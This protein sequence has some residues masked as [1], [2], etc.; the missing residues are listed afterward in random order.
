MTRSGKEGVSSDSR[1]WPGGRGRGRGRGVESVCDADQAFEWGAPV[2]GSETPD[3]SP[4]DME[5]GSE[6]PAHYGR[7]RLSSQSTGLQ[8]GQVLTPVPTIPIPRSR[9]SASKSSIVRESSQEEKKSVSSDG[10]NTQPGTSRNPADQDVDDWIKTRALS[11]RHLQNQVMTL[12]KV[13][14]RLQKECDS[15]KSGAECLTSLRSSVQAREMPSSPGMRP[16]AAPST[17]STS[18]L[19]C[20][21]SGLYS[22]RDSLS[23]SD[24]P[25][26][27]DRVASSGAAASGDM[28]QGVSDKFEQ[29]GV[30]RVSAEGRS[31]RLMD[32]G[33]LGPQAEDA[34]NVDTRDLETPQRLSFPLSGKVAMT[35]QFLPSFNTNVNPVSS[36][37]SSSTRPWGILVPQSDSLDTPSEP[38]YFLERSFFVIGK[39]R[40]CDHIIQDSRFADKPLCRIQKEDSVVFITSFTNNSPLFVNGSLLRKQARIPLQ[41]GDE[42]CFVGEHRSYFLYFITTADLA[43]V[44]APKSLEGRTPAFGTSSSPLLHR[45]EEASG[46]G[47]FSP[48]REANECGESNPSSQESASSRKRMFSAADAESN[49]ASD[50]EMVVPT[51]TVS[52]PSSPP[53]KRSQLDKDEDLR[54]SV[55]HAENIRC[56]SQ[57]SRD[58][59]AFVAESNCILS[60]NTCT[61]L[62]EFPYHLSPALKD[63]LIGS[64]SLILQEPSMCSV[65]SQFSALSQRVLLLAPLGGERYCSLLAEGMAH[66]FGADLFVLDQVLQRRTSSERKPLDW[67]LLDSEISA[68]SCNQSA[69]AVWPLPLSGHHDE[70]EDEDDG[71]QS[72][73]LLPPLYEDY[74]SVMKVGFAS[75]DR[76]LSGHVTSS[77]HARH[78]G[79]RSGVGSAKDSD[80]GR[81]SGRKGGR[82]EDWKVGSV[83]EFRGSGT[84]D[85]PAARNHTALAQ[86][87]LEGAMRLCAGNRFSTPPVPKL[88]GLRPGCRGIVQLFFEKNPRIVCVKFE[89]PLRGSHELPQVCPDG[90]GVFVPRTSLRF[91]GPEG[92]F[93][94]SAK[95]G[96]S[97]SALP[98]TGHVSLTTPKAA[99]KKPDGGEEKVPQPMECDSLPLTADPGILKGEQDGPCATRS[100]SKDR[101]MGA[102]D[103]SVG[104][105]LPD[106]DEPQSRDGGEPQQSGDWSI[107]FGASKSGAGAG[108]N[109]PRCGTPSFEDPEWGPGQA[110]MESL[111]MTVDQKKCIIHEAM[112]ILKRRQSS[113]PLI[114]Y[115]GDVEGVLSRPWDFARELS[116]LVRNIENKPVVILGASFDTKDQGEEKQVGSGDRGACGNSLSISNRSLSNLLLNVPPNAPSGRTPTATLMLG[117]NS[118]SSGG[119]GFFL[120]PSV[121]PPG[122]GGSEPFYGR[123]AEMSG[124]HRLSRMMHAIGS[125]GLDLSPNTRNLRTSYP[126]KVERKSS[127]MKS[128]LERMFP[129]RM[130]IVKPSHGVLGAEW[131]RRLRED[132][133]QRN[134]DFNVEIFQQTLKKLNT[135][136]EAFPEEKMKEEKFDRETIERMCAWAVS[137]ELSS[138]RQSLDEKA[139]PSYSPVNT[140]DNGS[141]AL[142]VEEARNGSPPLA[143]DV[144][145]ASKAPLLSQKSIIYALSLHE[146]LIKERSPKVTWLETERMNEF[147]KRLLGDVILAE[148]IGVSFQDIGSLDAFKKTLREVVMLPLQR[149][150]L[151]RRGNLAKAVKGLLLFGPPGTGKTMLAKAVATESGANFLNINMSSIGSKWFG[152]A[153][154]YA[155]AVFTLARK[156]APCII[157]VDE[158]DSMLGQRS[159]SGEHEAMRKIKNE[160]MSGWDGLK[161]KDTEQVLVLGATNRPFDLDEAVLRRMPRR[162]LVDT[163]DLEERRRIL[164]VILREEEIHPSLSILEIAAK[165]DGFTGSDLKNLCVNAAYRPLR[166]LIDREEKGEQISSA[167]L[168]PLVLQ[169]FIEALK[170]ISPSVSEDSSSIQELRQW[171]DMYGEGG[172]RSRPTLPYFM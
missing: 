32:R 105:E 171:N 130:A 131:E 161:S 158:I 91:L 99:A 78:K 66:H 76:H 14:E 83:V 152:E 89:Q 52:S 114:L 28:R 148:D 12:L 71:L 146:N 54:S 156:I 107:K 8:E 10:I 125:H 43:T 39:S 56:P 90:G 87:Q 50:I 162:L 132:M 149:P 104:A 116:E 38:A 18:D 119:S 19:W 168:R 128:L 1:S 102:G 26:S 9:R 59:P 118:T 70:D 45:T 94:C 92:N 82:L 85:P 11:V 117:V 106:Q 58:I 143:M 53:R 111:G 29:E 22:L 46:T 13:V 36:A 51:A 144:D 163:P 80:R 25:L 97:S 67:D 55:R 139:Q 112:E 113:R 34:S 164:E 60:P 61:P 145:G 73:S 147:E 2:P 135:Q 122:S 137:Y 101:P 74:P 6:E 172:S 98:A 63:E 142:P 48:L 16:A 23:A 47:S 20:P 108:D 134:L 153:E 77:L 120:Q 115:L 151:F 69:D 140:Q 167:D 84:E 44:S 57:L 110:S 157:F 123:V 79:S 15:S 159:K 103:P 17:V 127:E 49:L 31:T 33:K 75:L 35:R 3:C 37:L 124:T 96:V 133:H 30:F 138:R 141:E 129:V 81:H 136:C 160:F 86:L 154:R 41:S 62:A 150:E 100:A 155:G 40:Q 121:R 126:L 24:G 4:P 27:V 169:D 21:S 65:A 7:T 72:S 166:E 170:E 5:C 88:S 93:P 64:I 68:A 165:T 95:S 109:T 42:I